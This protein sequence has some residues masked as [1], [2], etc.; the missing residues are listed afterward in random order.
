MPEQEQAL[1]LSKLYFDSR[2]GRTGKVVEVTAD[3]V[4]WMR[5][6]RGGVEWTADPDHLSPVNEEEP[7]E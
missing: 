7:S 6:V 3:G 2:R 5:P 1:D 4:V